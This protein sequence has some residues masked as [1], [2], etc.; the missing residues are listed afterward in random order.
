MAERRGERTSQELMLSNLERQMLRRGASQIESERSNRRRRRTSEEEEESKSV[1][2]RRPEVHLVDNGESAVGEHC[3]DNAAG[4][5]CQ[6]DRR[7]NEL[8]QPHC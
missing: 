6:T 4:A 5:P 2:N 3:A 1:G 8:C 7:L